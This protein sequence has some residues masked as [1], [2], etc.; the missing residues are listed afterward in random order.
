MTFYLVE[1]FSGTGSFGSAAREVAEGAG[2]AFRKL[3]VD[4][5]P[6]YNPSTC[7]D[8]LRWDYE[9]ELATF[10]RDKREGDL[11]WVHASPP[12][13]EFSIMKNGQQRNLPLADSI[14]QR[15]LAIIE[16]LKPTYWTIENPK[17]LLQKRPYMAALDK[18]KHLTSYCC[19]GRPFRKDTRLWSNL[20][21]H[22]PVCRAGTYCGQKLAT[23]KHA[24]SA[25]DRDTR[26]TD[27]TL[28]RARVS[29]DRLYAIPP[30]LCAAVVR[31]GLRSAGFGTGQI[32]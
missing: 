29:T 18:H 13:N 8:I 4:I 17:G 11:L 5:H 9:S 7:T 24:L 31:A 1:L 12:C 21:L 26:A 22:L 3:S 28:L 6:K 10:L 32:D 19:W 30:E 23:G 16:H 2:M 20:E 14:V 27:G 15:A 25:K